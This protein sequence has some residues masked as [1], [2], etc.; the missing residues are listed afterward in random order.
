M[1]KL[2]ALLAVAGSSIVTFAT[3]TSGSSSGP[4]FSAATT[5]LTSIQ[6]A[7][8]DWVEDALPILVAIGSA[9]LAFGVV[10]LV[11][12]LVKSWGNSAK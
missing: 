1:K 5:A 4:D 6:G 2:L 10:K 7:L 3:E 12:R 9:F 11:F 8:T